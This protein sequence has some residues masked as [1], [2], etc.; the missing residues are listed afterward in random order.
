MKRLIEA[1]RKFRNFWKL[2]EKDSATYTPFKK[3]EGFSA[4][5]YEALH[6][7]L[8]ILEMSDP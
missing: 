4:R 3:T 7:M 5:S 1:V 6:R 2:T 8:D